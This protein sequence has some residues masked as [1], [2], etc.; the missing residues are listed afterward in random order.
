MSLPKLLPLLVAAAL[1]LPSADTR[2]DDDDRNWPCTV[3]L[4]LANPKGA[5]SEPQC[6]APIKK[7]FRALARGHVFPVC[8]MGSGSR[9]HETSTQRFTGKNCPSQYRYFGGHSGT[10]PACQFDGA[11]TY[12]LDEHTRVRLLWNEDESISET[13][14]DQR[15]DD[16]DDTDE[17]RRPR[18][19]QQLR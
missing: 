15:V 14:T 2:A 11:I 16:E 18:P 6:Q 3:A 10:T 17:L 13:L 12:R 9:Q 1:A 5:M 4:C 7:L 19:G 8:V